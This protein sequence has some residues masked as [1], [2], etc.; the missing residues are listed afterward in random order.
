MSVDTNK[1][2]YLGDSVYA[3]WDGYA[4]TV[5]TD[6][7]FGPQNVIVLEPQVLAALNGFAERMKA[8]GA[9]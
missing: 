9:A 8:G 1:T 2:D 4:V 6:N 7:G 5:Y 3:K